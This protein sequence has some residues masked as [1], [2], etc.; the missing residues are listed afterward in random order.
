MLQPSKCWDY[1]CVAPG[2]HFAGFLNWESH[3]ILESKCSSNDTTWLR[4][5]AGWSAHSHSPSQ[6]LLGLV[7]A[8]HMLISTWW[9]SCRTLFLSTSSHVTARPFL[10]TFYTELKRFY[11]CCCCSVSLRV[12]QV[13]LFVSASEYTDFFPDVNLF[14]NHSA[15]TYPHHQHV[16]HKR[17]LGPVSLPFDIYPKKIIAY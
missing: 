13:T 17:V 11:F 14:I 12:D 5:T 4:T 7:P 8:A 16:M 10:R 15:L 9:L 6:S 2:S 3:H 1:R